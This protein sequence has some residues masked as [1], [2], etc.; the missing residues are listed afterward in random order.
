MGPLIKINGL[1]LGSFAWMV[2]D[3][4]NISRDAF[5][6]AGLLF[7]VHQHLPCQSRLI[8]TA[9]EDIKQAKNRTNPDHYIILYTRICKL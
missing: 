3:L 1:R 5:E 4:Y 2:T 7:S 8:L 9:S 6:V